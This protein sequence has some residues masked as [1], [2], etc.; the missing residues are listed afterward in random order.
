VADLRVQIFEIAMQS[1]RDAADAVNK[2]SQTQLS[3]LDAFI[4]G[5]AALGQS[6]AQLNARRIEIMRNQMANLLPVAT[7]A[8][9]AGNIALQ[10]EIWIQM[11]DIAATIIELTQ[12]MTQDVIDQIN[13]VAQRRLG[14]LDLVSRLLEATGTVGMW[15]TQTLGGE[16]FNRTDILW[17]RQAA[18][19]QQRAQLQQVLGQQQALP[20][21]Q[22]NIQIIQSLEDQI[23][24][25]DVT[26]AENVRA[27]H[28]AR[29]E[30]VNQRAGF[31]LGINDLQKQILE[32]TGQITGNT[33]RAA[34]LG[35]AM[36]RDAVL[37]GKGNELQS[38]YNDAVSRR[39][40]QAMQ[41]LETA[42]L[43]NQVAI[44]QNTLAVNELSGTMTDPQ[45]F[46][47][48]AWQQFREAI[49][50]GMGQVLPQYQIPMAQTGGIAM[51]AGLYHLEA[52]ELWRPGSWEQRK[53]GDINI[54]INE[55]GQPIDTTA[56]AGKIGF[57]R[58]V[59]N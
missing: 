56:L 20:W 23:A 26:M 24:E 8:G 13:N 31:V 40:Q 44:L 22:Q 7:A 4:R 3:A 11:N 16:Q 38:L 53:E 41:D 15:A 57:A 14:R 21:D 5:A 10:E 30:D 9:A 39:D 2:S 28:Q 18:L 43:E 29:F 27:Y 34:L 12:Q 55:A 33:D 1:I 54:E 59:M 50:T 48:S 37:R 19:G 6:T 17:N 58:K 35:L 25:L 51:K 45:T 52:G 49:F 32:L 36:Q 47:S 46:T 42:I